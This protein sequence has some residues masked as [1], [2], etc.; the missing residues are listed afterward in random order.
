MKDDLGLMELSAHLK[1]LRA[2]S[3]SKPNPLLGDRSHCFFKDLLQ[4]S[5]SSLFTSTKK[6]VLLAQASLIRSADNVPYLS[7]SF[8]YY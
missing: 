7:V 3:L 8:Y 5:F 1:R 4:C 2:V 6:E